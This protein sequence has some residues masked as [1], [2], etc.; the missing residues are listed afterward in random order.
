MKYF[1]HEDDDVSFWI[2]RA[3]FEAEH[4]NAKLAID[5]LQ[6]LASEFPQNPHI[7]YDQGLIRYHY[8]HTGQGTCAREFFLSAETLA[9]RARVRGTRWQ[10]AHYLA[11][12]ATSREEARNWAEIALS[13]LPRLHSVHSALRALLKDLDSSMPYHLLLNSYALS[14]FEHG[15]PGGAASQVEIALES[16]SYAPPDEARVRLLRAECLRQLD[17]AEEHQRRQNGE[18]FPPADRLAL[19]EAVEELDRALKIEPY[20]A[21]MWNFKA[22]WC[23]GLQRHSESIACADRA[24][25]LRPLRY[26]R[27]WVN[28]ATALYALRRDEEALECARRA[29][30]EATASGGEFEDDVAEATRQIE[31]YSEP[32]RPATLDDLAPKM[33]AVLKAAITASSESSVKESQVPSIARGLLARILHTG[34]T[35]AISFVPMMA[36]LLS[37]FSPEV[38]LEV[39]NHASRSSVKAYTLCMNATMYLASDTEGVQ[40]HDAARFVVLNLFQRVLLSPKFVRQIY[41]EAVLEVSRPASPPLCRIDQVLRAEMANIDEQLCS[42]IADQEPLTPD[43]LTRGKSMILTQFEGDPHEYE[44][45]APQMG[46]FYTNEPGEWA[47]QRLWKYVKAGLRTARIRVLGPAALRPRSKK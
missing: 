37:D 33:A 3:H 34:S 4:G 38:A 29:L 22:A 41:R 47:V 21:K 26:S 39:I 10:A 2:N 6:E 8:H 15:E 12:L 18:V 1:H 30:S 25:S 16:G 43:E 23:N 31:L 28:K 45:D 20:D 24:I 11:K 13:I 32:R 17:R 42:L 27:P 36:Q 9:S 14:A 7:P 40:Q 44:M 46:L 35:R 19:L 5:R